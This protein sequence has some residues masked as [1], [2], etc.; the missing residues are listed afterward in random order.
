M[1]LTPFQYLFPN[2]ISR[3]HGEYSFQLELVGIARTLI[4]SGQD[5][6]VLINTL[7][8]WHI[9]AVTSIACGTRCND[10]ASS[11]PER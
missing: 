2:G 4:R 6:E 3:M 9:Y 8:M 10:K 11:Y 1:K 5:P 7:S